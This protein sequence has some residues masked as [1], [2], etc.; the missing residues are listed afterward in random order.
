MSFNLSEYV[1]KIFYGR[2]NENVFKILEV[3][4]IIYLIKFVRLTERI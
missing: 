2:S 1:A 4:I 3:S